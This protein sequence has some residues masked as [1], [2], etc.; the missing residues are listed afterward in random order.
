VPG[1]ARGASRTVISLSV[2]TYNVHGLASFLVDDDPEARMP[3]ISSR[4]NAYDVALLQESWTYGEALGSRATHAVKERSG[5]F[6]PG[7][8]LQ[9]GLATFA[10]PRLRA[11]TRAPLG[12]CAGWLGG[13][14]D[15]LASKG[16]L[17]VRLALADGVEIDFW[18]THLDA[19]Q[20]EADRA[21]RAVQLERLA[22]R[23]RE[24]SHDG[25][26]V[27]AGDFNL[28]EANTADRA[29]LDRFSS[30]LALRDSG[31][32]AAAD[33]AF[34][35]KNIDFILYRSGGGVELELLEAGE[36]R[37]FSDGPSPLS[38]HPA[39]FARFAVSGP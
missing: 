4:L 20:D 29:L 14:N 5:A 15:C 6:D 2:L 24:L 7:M 21:A 12:A 31:A 17:R 30:D 36:A 11:V 37:E 22:A 10:R 8:L 1:V 16:F 38:D 19:G 35:A 9:S 27:I 33:G 26:L 32:L 34:A 28:D 39:L 23:V 3:E 25:A 13:A 18:T